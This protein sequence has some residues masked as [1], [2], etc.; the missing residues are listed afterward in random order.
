M[1]PDV[2][3]LVPAEW[4]VL[5]EIR[6]RA[7]RD[8]PD[9]FASADVSEMVLTDHQWR[10]RCR[11]GTWVVARKRDEV[12]GVAGL[13]DAELPHQERYVEGVWV[14]P[15]HRRQGVCRTLIDKLAA[16]EGRDL[17]LWVLEGNPGAE[18][19]Y[20]RIGFVW[21]DDKPKPIDTERGR[22]WEKRMRLR[23]TPSPQ[24]LIER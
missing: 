16:D 6:L 23:V 21:T 2:R 20:D 10:Q 18:R 9:A 3:W 22:R 4:R 13:V 24:A 14:A 15:M 17:C 19:A 7:L 11:A 8:S 12:I 5:R 1:L